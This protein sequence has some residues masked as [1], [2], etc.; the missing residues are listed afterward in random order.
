MSLY[1]G[2][3]G[4]LEYFG[5]LVDEVDGGAAPG[6]AVAVEGDEAVGREVVVLGVVCF[7]EG[8]GSPADHASPVVG[9]IGTGLL[10]HAAEQ[11]GLDELVGGVG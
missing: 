1:L 5:V 7:K 2:L 3:M 6:V 10:L 9:E 4:G 8:V 11:H